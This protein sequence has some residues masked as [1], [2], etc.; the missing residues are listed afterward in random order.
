MPQEQDAGVPQQ[1]N[2]VEHAVSYKL[3]KLTLVNSGYA[4]CMMTRREKTKNYLLN[5]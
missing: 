5:Q 3:L 1:P 4:S 2:V